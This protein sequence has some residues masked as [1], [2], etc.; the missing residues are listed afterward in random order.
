[1]L[2]APC[3]ESSPT[4]LSNPTPEPWLVGVTLGAITLIQQKESWLLW[5]LVSEVGFSA[6]RR[7]G[8]VCVAH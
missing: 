6:L 5:G 7:K 8:V 2:K 1:M 3:A 4:P